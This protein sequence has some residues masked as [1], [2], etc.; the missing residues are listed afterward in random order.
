MRC[1][2]PGLLCGRHL[3]AEQGNSVQNR[4]TAGLACCAVSAK[5]PFF[6]REQVIGGNPEKAKWA[7]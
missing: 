7:R 2:Y 3:F 5:N 1:T 6:L 4:N